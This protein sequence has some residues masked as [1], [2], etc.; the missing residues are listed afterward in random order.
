MIMQIYIKI[1]S[2]L[3]HLSFLVHLQLWIYLYKATLNQSGYIFFWCNFSTLGCLIQERGSWSIFRFSPAF[4]HLIETPM[5][6]NFSKRGQKSNFI[7][8][9][10]EQKTAVYLVFYLLT[11]VWKDAIA[12]Y[13][14][15]E[16]M[17]IFLINTK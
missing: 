9:H 2:Q 8:M 17:V 3:L 7:S 4:L 1:G 16:A 11:V 14:C 15:F 10:K 12:L 5:F 6:I 13:S